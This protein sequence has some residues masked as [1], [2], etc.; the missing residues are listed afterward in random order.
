MSRKTPSRV[1]TR[2]EQRKHHLRLVLV[3]LLG[4]LA[5]ATFTVLDLLHDYSWT[6]IQAHEADARVFGESVTVLL[7]G[8]WL[9]SVGPGRK[10]QNSPPSR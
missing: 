10:E 1:E 3:F 8:A 2:R 6:H 5:F 7:F 4:T 9:W